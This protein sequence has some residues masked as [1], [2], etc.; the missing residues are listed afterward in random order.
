MM[1]KH[2]KKLLLTLTTFFWNA[3]DNST[4]PITPYVPDPNSSSSVNPNS[5]SEAN[6]SA[7]SSSTIAESS[8][9]EME[10]MPLYGV[11]ME[12]CTKT[13]HDSTWVCS[14][15]RSCVESVKD[16]EQVPS[17]TGDQICAKY[18][19]L[20]VKEKSYKCDDGKIY[21]EAEFISNY[22]LIELMP[23][24]YGPPCM[25]NNTCDEEK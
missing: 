18:G 8:S 17:C 16:K 22:E 20:V 11:V 3:C 14:D 5:S 23:A 9:S 4:S 13:E 2:W 1:Y 21:N 10:V 12:S 24:L 7:S 25:F 6:G 19:V 15:G